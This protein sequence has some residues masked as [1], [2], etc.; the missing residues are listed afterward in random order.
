ML[1]PTYGR[2][3]DL[4]W[5]T[6][7]GSR[8][9]R[10]SADSQGAGG[11]PT[12]ARLRTQLR[13]GTQI[14]RFRRVHP[15]TGTDLGWP[16]GCGLIFR[17]RVTLIGQEEGA[18]DTAVANPSTETL[19]VPITLSHRALGRSREV[20]PMRVLGAPEGT[21]WGS[22]WTAKPRAS[23]CC[24]F[25]VSRGPVSLSARP[26]KLGVKF[27]TRRRELS[28]SRNLHSTFPLSPALPRLSEFS[29][30]GS[31]VHSCF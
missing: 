9:C 5:V 25:C 2:A 13:L 12:R 7:P 28:R 15:E 11:V 21:P 8:G 30:P 19:L 31:L 24:C 23:L 10:Q 18:G 29:L 3:E 14:G 16:G 1:P 6:H 26:A 20:A 17:R 22:S 4:S 27:G